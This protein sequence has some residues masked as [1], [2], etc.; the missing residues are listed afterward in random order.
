ML[1][2]QMTTFPK[3]VRVEIISLQEKQSDVRFLTSKGKPDMYF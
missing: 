1:N 2:K 3:T